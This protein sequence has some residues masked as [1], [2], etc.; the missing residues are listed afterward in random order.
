MPCINGASLNKKKYWYVGEQ[1]LCFLFFG[2]KHCQLPELNHRRLAL[3]SCRVAFAVFKRWP[4]SSNRFNL[5]TRLEADYCIAL[6]INLDE[7]K[8]GRKTRPTNF[9]ADGARKG[10]FQEKC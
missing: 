5:T 6:L 10:S 9:E 3:Y 8:V 1:K 7:L 4:V 2:D